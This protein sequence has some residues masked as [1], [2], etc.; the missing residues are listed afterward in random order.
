MPANPMHEAPEEHVQRDQA[1]VEWRELLRFAGV[2]VGGLPAGVW[3]VWKFLL[4]AFV[5]GLLR[6]F[7]P[8]WKPHI[9]ALVAPVSAWLLS[10]L[11]VY[12]AL[13]CAPR[14]RHCS[15]QTRLG[16]AAVCLL[17]AVL[18]GIAVH[19][20]SGSIVPRGGRR[21]SFAAGVPLETAL[22]VPPYSLTNSELDEAQEAVRK[23]GGVTPGLSLTRQ[24]RAWAALLPPVFGFLSA[25][26]VLSVPRQR[27]VWF[28]LGLQ[29]VLMVLLI[30]G[31]A[32]A[33]GPAV[34]RRPG[35]LAQQVSW[36]VLGSLTIG[37]AAWCRKGWGI[38]QAG[39]AGS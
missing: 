24:L 22:T 25:A 38:S 21:E 27:T 29:L 6:S 39:N 34:L 3:L 26:A 5:L 15:H 33:M 28:A 23:Q 7:P 37:A 11:L 8:V 1:A 19:V 31:M 12:I 30:Q 18:C 16:A 2:V 20:L 9:D 4:P 32:M 17:A 10:A 14:L 13:A 36:V 35:P